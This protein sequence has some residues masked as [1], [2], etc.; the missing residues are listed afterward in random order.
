MTVSTSTN[1]RYYKE[2]VKIETQAQEAHQLL[3]A[4]N[5]NAYN[6]Y[7]DTASKFGEPYVRENFPEITEAVDRIEASIAGLQTLRSSSARRDALMNSLAAEMSYLA[8]NGDPSID[9][10]IQLRSDLNALSSFRLE[11]LDGIKINFWYVH[12]SRL[13]NFLEKNSFSGPAIAG[14]CEVKG[15]EPKTLYRALEMISPLWNL[16][17]DH[18]KEAFSVAEKLDEYPFDVTT[19][20]ES[21]LSW[22]E[23]HLDLVKSI[24]ELRSPPNKAAL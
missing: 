18:L 4:A 13:V 10:V 2:I 21:A 19:L 15:V 8:A 1:E 22:P 24:I 7:Y 9:P 14:W 17:P 5:A 20:L 11:K 3:F 16:Y 23:A 6:Q 12:A